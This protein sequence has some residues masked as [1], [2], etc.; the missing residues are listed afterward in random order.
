MTDARALLAQIR[1]DLDRYV[2]YRVVVKAHKG[3]RR[4]VVREG[5]LERTYPSLFVIN[6]G[7]EQQNR[8]VSY[9]YSE[10]LTATVE[11]TVLEVAGQPGRRLTV[12]RERA[13]APAPPPS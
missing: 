5:T 8:R 2:G 12:N 11:V 1:Q 6:L 4:T 7:P 10:L 13:A 3:R 9:T